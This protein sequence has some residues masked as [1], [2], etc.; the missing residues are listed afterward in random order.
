LFF[1]CTRKTLE[2]FVKLD[3]I[4]DISV[5]ILATEIQLDVHGSSKISIQDILNQIHESYD[6]EL[7]YWFQDIVLDTIMKLILQTALKLFIVGIW[8]QNI[9]NLIFDINTVATNY[10]TNVSPAW[11]FGFNMLLKFKIDYSNNTF[12]MP[13]LPNY[14]LDHIHLKMKSNLSNDK[15]LESL[16]VK[17]VV[18]LK[19]FIFFYKYRNYHRTEQ[20][21]YYMPFIKNKI[22]LNSIVPI[23]SSHQIKGVCNF[24]KSIYSICYEA[25]TM[26]QKLSYTKV[27]S[28]ES[29]VWVIINC[30]RGYF[31]TIIKMFKNNDVELKKIAYNVVIVLVNL[32]NW[33]TDQHI[34]IDNF[35]RVVN[36]I[37]I[38]IIM[39]KSKNC[40]AQKF[41]FTYYDNNTN[42]IIKDKKVIENTILNFFQINIEQ[43]KNK[44]F[45]DSEF[46]F[47]NLQYLYNTYIRNSILIKKYGQIIKVNW[48]GNEETIMD[49]YKNSS[50]DVIN[51]EFLFARYDIYFKFYIAVYYYE[52]RKCLIVNKLKLKC[53][54]SIKEYFGDFWTDTFPQEL[55]YF[56]SDIKALVNYSYDAWVKLNSLLGIINADKRALNDVKNN[57]KELKNK[58]EKQF[59]QFNIVFKDSEK[60]T[61]MKRI[62]ENMKKPFKPSINKT[63]ENEL[64]V[65][66]KKFNELF[67]KFKS[68]T[69]Q[70]SLNVGTSIDE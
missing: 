52:M 25:Y 29:Q 60:L 65:S 37:A 39:Y 58:I 57:I 49:L 42:I 47:F 32:S 46:N 50:N 33:I 15:Y 24:L 67:T 2:H 26:L 51:H 8:P 68:E 28:T 62:K 3:L 63:F 6:I 27:I 56:I 31:F 38:Q 14:Y 17:V 20:D 30:I 69:S 53:L 55:D 4:D 10:D 64:K 5:D 54:A 70:I 16:L 9:V 34:Y 44:S 41:G 22:K 36:V 61:F 18:H 11:I 19:Y 43:Y 35:K 45:E 12:D 66:V 21:K 48:N 13:V 1:D 7:I 59:K 23:N 40:S